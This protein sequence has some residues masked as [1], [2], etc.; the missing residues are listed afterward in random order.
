MELKIFVCDRCG[1]RFEKQYDCLEEI[2]LHKWHG[3][4]A[5]SAVNRARV[6]ED[7][8][9][10]YNALGERH[11]LEYGAWYGQFK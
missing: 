2:P 4:V 6:C 3:S 7:C 11:K 10:S 8:L 9:A 5:V 1:E